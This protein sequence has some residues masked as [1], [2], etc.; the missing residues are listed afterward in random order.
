M[1]CVGFLISLAAFWCVDS[2]SPTTYSI[3]G[4]A[5]KLPLS[6]L[7]IWW[8]GTK[9]NVV[10]GS[11]GLAALFGGLLYAVTKPSRAKQEPK[12]NGTE[13]KTNGHGNKTNGGDSLHDTHKPNNTTTEFVIDID[14]LEA[15]S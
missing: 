13:N 1:Q 7:S 14:K 5:N 11:S 6:L 9:F 2:N 4:A 8:F 10:G 3:V 12:T 15:K